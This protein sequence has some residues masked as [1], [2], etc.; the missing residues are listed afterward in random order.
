M[1]NEKNERELAYVV[2]I[3]NLEPIPD[4][5]RIEKATVN[6]WSLV[7]PKGDFKI[8][9]KAIYFEVDSLLPQI[10]VFDF[11]ASSKYK[12]KTRKIAN[13]LSQ[14]LLMPLSAFG[15]SD[16]DYPLGTFVTEKLGVTNFTTEK[17]D[18]GSRADAFPQNLPY[19]TR[20]NEERIENCFNKLN[21]RT[22]IPQ[23]IL[24]LYATEKVDGSSTT[25][26]MR[27]GGEL[28]VYSH[29]LRRYDKGSCFW[30]NAIKYNIADV[31]SK[32]L[33]GS[34]F[35]YIAIQ[36]ESIG[37]GIQGNKYKIDGYDFYVFNIV[38]SKGKFP[39]EFMALTCRK[40]NLKRVPVS[41][42]RSIKIPS[43][44]YTIKALKEDAKFNSYINPNVKAEGIVYRTNSGNVHFKNVAY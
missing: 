31:L 35:D 19:L 21:S 23:E 18:G 42:D 12:V 14:G 36:G 44:S 16:N 39:L 22:D 32:V 41:L 40:Y 3:D 30:Q 2:K 38:S 6:G 9:D 4:K 28:E 20:T 11:M 8:G 37:I 13:V 34:D 27:R 10:D 7:V 43:T 15:F 29:N 33:A 25:Y 1:L 17:E 26:L 24:Y 5:D